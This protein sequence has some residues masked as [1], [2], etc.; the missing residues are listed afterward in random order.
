MKGFWGTFFIFLLWATAGIYYIHTKENKDISIKY[1][2]Q[3]LT[4]NQNA[5]DSKT[6]AYIADFEKNEIKL[7]TAIIDSNSLLNP[8]EVD[9]MSNDIGYMDLDTLS[10]SPK[11]TTSNTNL[12]ISEN[13]TVDS[14]LLADEIK[15]SIAISDT[16]D[17]DKDEPIIEY[18]GETVVKKNPNVASQIFY[19]GYANTDLIVGD[20]LISYATELKKILAKNPTKKVMIIGHT[21]NV[22]NAKDNFTI[23][24][25]KSRQIKW[26]LTTRRGIERSKITAIS[27]GESSPI[28]SNES[29]WGRKKNDRI[30]II[31]D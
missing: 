19:P 25:K 29:V 28:E 14:Q 6:N 10:K 9:S 18:R 7:D 16:V 2:E 4:T 31:I 24:L 11:S 1:F 21:D 17:I 5:S 26:Y 15:K 23:G 3:N 27:R 13:T 12:Y 8:S 22:G 30:E 20:D